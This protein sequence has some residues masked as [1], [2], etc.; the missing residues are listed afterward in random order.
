MA[1]I[2]ALMPL[3]PCPTLVIILLAA[4]LV[5]LGLLGVIVVWHALAEVAREH[6]ANDWVLARRDAQR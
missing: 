2:R 3:V 6:R 1:R 5:S 4:W